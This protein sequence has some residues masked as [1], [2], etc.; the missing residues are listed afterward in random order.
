[1]QL[2]VVKSPSNPI[3]VALRGEGEAEAAV[4]TKNIVACKSVIYLVDRVLLP[5]ELATQPVE[6]EPE[7]LLM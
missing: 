1:M 4:L 3:G 6:E 7:T 5:F 2:S